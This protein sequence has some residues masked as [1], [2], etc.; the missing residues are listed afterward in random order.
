M[1]ILILWLIF[2]S[3]FSYG[4]GILSTSNIFLEDPN[5]IES[6]FNFLKILEKLTNM[7]LVL[8]LKLQKLV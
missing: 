8:H 4:V 1:M 5:L 7:C 2:R 6:D 3:S